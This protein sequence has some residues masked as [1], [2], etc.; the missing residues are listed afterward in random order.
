[1]SADE[2]GAAPAP[3]RIGNGMAINRILVTGGTGFVGSKVVQAC[4][5]A[6]YDTCSCSRSEGVDLR[7]GVAATRSIRKLAPDLVVHCAAHVGGIGYVGEHAIEVF[8]DNLRISSG[9]MQGLRASGVKNLITVMPNC[10]YPGDKDTYREDE[11]WD[12][13]IHDS[14]LMYGLPRKTLWGLCRTYGNVTGLRS[15]HL[16]FPNM[17]GPGDHFEP[18]RSHALGALIAKVVEAGRTQAPH[19]VLWGSGRPVREWMYVTDASAAIV[20]FIQVFGENEA[21][22]NNHRIYNV[23]IAEGISILGLAE[24]IREAVGWNGSF[25]VD[26]SRPDGAVQKLLDGSRFHDLTGWAP[27]VSLRTGIAK[28]VQDYLS[29]VERELSHAN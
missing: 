10:T 17:Y 29:S 15:A 11:W 14:V 7:D 2:G 22:L 18:Q 5:D 3:T 13:P 27:A 6:D 26:P 19:V 28:T 4:R 16:I 8:E 12:G 9:L 20:R 24:L 21:L 1:M 25:T 23:G